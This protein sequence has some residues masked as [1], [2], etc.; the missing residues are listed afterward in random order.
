[1]V[2]C[3]KKIIILQDTQKKILRF[4]R[5][6]RREM[7]PEHP[8]GQTDR[9]CRR[10]LQDDGRTRSSNITSPPVC[11]HA[12][13][14]RSPC[15]TRYNA[16]VEASSLASSTPPP[17]SSRTSSPAQWFKVVSKSQRESLGLRGHDNS[18][19]TPRHHRPDSPRR[20]PVWGWTGSEP[21]RKGT[22]PLGRRTGRGCWN[23]QR[24]RGLRVHWEGL[25][26]ARS[27]WD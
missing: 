26:A 1:M 5:I 9:S 6:F 19:K 17:P 16:S 27:D 8:E 12:P 4:C 22:E 14:D 20:A 15:V 13:S 24:T 10:R 23:G 25:C 11:P 18:V 21:G 7:I 3:T 2:S